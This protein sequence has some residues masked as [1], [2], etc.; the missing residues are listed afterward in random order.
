VLFRSVG[1]S[2][3]VVYNSLQPKATEAE[4]SAIKD[5]G[6]ESAILLAL[7]SRNPTV[8][9]RVQVL[10]ALLPLAYEAGIG[11]ILID[12][13]NIDIPDPGPVSKTVYLVKEKYGLP[14]GA[15]THNAVSM[16][17]KRRKLDSEQ[18]LIASTVANI[19]PIVM[20]ANF[21]LYG[22]VESASEAYFHC[23]LADAYVAHSMR[24]EYKMEPSTREHPMYKIFKG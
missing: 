6:I 11:N 17:R 22:P 15:G 5:A 9:G 12:T 18:R 19:L 8:S 23:G 13:A 1:I 21:T 4:L 16:W 3:R 10:E 14:A 20:G 24:Q 2:E 7:N